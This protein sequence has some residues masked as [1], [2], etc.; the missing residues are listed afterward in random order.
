[1][2]AGIFIWAGINFIEAECTYDDLHFVQAYELCSSLNNCIVTLDE[3]A[4]Y[5]QQLPFCKGAE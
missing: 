1:M 3:T 2:W 4:R 5:T